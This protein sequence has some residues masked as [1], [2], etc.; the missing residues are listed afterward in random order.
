MTIALPHSLESAA[1]ASANRSAGAPYE[2]APRPEEEHDRERRDHRARDL[3]MIV[4]QLLERAA[5]EAQ[6]QARFDRGGRGRSR[7]GREERELAHDATGAALE[8][9]HVPDVDADP[10]FGHDEQPVFD[11]PALD[12]GGAGPERDLLEQARD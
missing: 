3:G 8:Q 10:A 11:T 1:P 4:E 2:H 12:D 7:C 9:G 6:Q 5:A